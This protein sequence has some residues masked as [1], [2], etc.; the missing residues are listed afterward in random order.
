MLFSPRPAADQD[1]DAL[2]ERAHRQRLNHT[3]RFAASG[4][5]S[6]IWCQ[7]RQWR[8]DQ[9]VPARAVLHLLVAV[10]VPVAAALSAAPLVYG[11]QPLA[12]APQPIPQS[13][14]FVVPIAPIQLDTL[15]ADE[16]S[17]PDS[18]FAAI[19]ALAPQVLRP[20]LL[21]VQPVAATIAAAQANVRGGPGTAYD[22]IATLPAGASLQL[23][24]RYEDWY[25]AQTDGGQTVW[26]AAE[27][28]DTDIIAAEFLPEATTIPALPP[29]KV[30]QVVEEGLNLR[31]GPGTSYVGM[32]KLPAGTQLDLLARY[33]EWFQVET[34]EG[35]MGWVT[36]EFLRI[37]GGIVE[38]VEIVSQIP[39][40]NPAL[41]ALVREPKVNLRG[42]PGTAYN[43]LGTLGADVQ[44]D[45]LA[46]HKDWFNVRTPRGTEGWVSSE[47]VQ[48]SPFVTRRVPQARSVPA[49]PQAAQRARTSAGIRGTVQFAPASATSGPAAFA[50]QFVGSRYVWGGSS[51]RG[52]D[53][54]G[55]TK[56]VYAQFGVSLP[57]SSAGQ[58][59]TSYGAAISDPAA[60]Q[61]GDIVFF[62]NTYR[63]GIS[64]VGIYIG[65]GNVVQAL[66][67]GR[68]VGV[69][70]L[71]ERYWSSRYYGAI[72][73]G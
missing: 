65:G 67:P 2:H 54:S 16:P 6:N 35:Q 12:P 60:L 42:G 15:A 62:V 71:N 22:K 37:D 4:L 61:P 11:P 10:L 43:T 53:C 5:L 51:P 52:F 17:V 25:K 7:V 32:L 8:R 24:A 31:D 68:G 3:R 57:H 28:M 64:H 38:R 44:L 13:S 18:A 73:P 20:E 34:S 14:D 59:S 21:A 19:D 46:R 63:R 69:A 33:Q 1:S 49:L 40:P 41:L 70:S 26:V 47:L 39:D 56:Y 30:G 36:G 58:Y 55:F 48:V 45:L 29:P 66:T 9:P 50:L 72:R 27:L 23:V